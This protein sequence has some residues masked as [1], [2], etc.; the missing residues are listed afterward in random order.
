MRFFDAAGKPFINPDN[1]CKGF[2]YFI[3]AWNNAVITLANDTSYKTSSVRLNLESGNVHFLSAG[4]R[5][6]VLPPGTVKA[7]SLFDSTVS[8]AITQYFSS[9]FSP[10][11]GH[12]ANWL[13]HVL[14]RGKIKI[15]ES[16]DKKIYT[17]KNEFSGETLQEYRT[18]FSYY[19]SCGVV[20]EKLRREKAF[21]MELMKDHTAEMESY[22]TREQTNFK[23]IS[24]I[25]KMIE[26]YNPLPGPT[27]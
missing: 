23:L 18:V 22:V 21:W 2:P 27:Q 15:L 20:I 5:E 24:D 9:G 8:P 14:T 3:N 7:L 6:M 11:G 17:D 26:Y 19:V 10:A 12:D 16:V 13:Y 1:N 25:K 4:N